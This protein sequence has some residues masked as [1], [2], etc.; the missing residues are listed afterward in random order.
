MSEIE[1]QAMYE[2]QFACFFFPKFTSTWYF[3]VQYGIPKFMGSL[4]TDLKLE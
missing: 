3:L 1:E 2:L 4:I